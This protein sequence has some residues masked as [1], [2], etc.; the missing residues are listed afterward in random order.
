MSNESKLF[1]H[2]ISYDRNKYVIG[3][4]FRSTGHLGINP[5]LW[6]CFSEFLKI[7]TMIREYMSFS[8]EKTNYD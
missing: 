8:I 6:L 2:M 5:W 7:L 3:R 1:F 4:R